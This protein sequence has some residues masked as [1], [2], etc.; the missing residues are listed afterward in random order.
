[1][2]RENILFI[3]PSFNEEKNIGSTVKNWL[4]IVKSI[5]GSLLLI[6][7]GGSTDKTQDR[8]RLLKKRYPKQLKLILKKTRDGHG[9]DLMTSYFFAVKSKYQWVFQTDS[10][11]HFKAKDFYKLWNLRQTSDFIL[12]NRKKRDDTTFRIALTVIVRF[13]IVLLFGVYIPDSNIPFRLIKTSYLKKILSKIKS[14]V[15][16]PNIFLSIL[17]SK[18]GLNL[19]NI[20][21]EHI[22][23]RKNNTKR[24]FN[25]AIKGF[26]EMADFSKNITQWSNHT[27]TYRKKDRIFNNSYLTSRTKRVLDLAIIFLLS[28]PIL[29]FLTFISIFQIFFSGFPVYFI[30]KRTG[31][32]GIVFDMYKFRTMYRGAEKDQIRYRKLN[33]SDGPVFKIRN[34]PR[35]TKFG[36]VLSRTGLDELPQIINVIKGNMSLVGPRPLPVSEANKLTKKDNLRLSVKPGITSS[37][38]VNGHHK[39]KF[40]EWMEL[41]RKYIQKADIV[42]DIRIL[43]KTTLI[44][45]KSIKSLS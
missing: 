9:T 22:N 28:I 31:M 5:K 33:E 15:F 43:L 4:P 23:L 1:M 7:D 21:L 37:W 20:S 35:Y 16:A 25:G 34:D 42:T 32:G 30:Q 19:Q 26:F 2:S 27:T 8:L 10:D 17:A 6:I 45:L 38:I 14:G 24:I 39:H 3:M 12:G 13:W 36:K 29:I 41:D 18:D 11:G 40:N 44:P